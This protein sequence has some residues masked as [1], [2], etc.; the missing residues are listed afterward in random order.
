MRLTKFLKRNTIYNLILIV[1]ISIIT[2]FLFSDV[3]L[4]L[5]SKV[6]MQH[7]G[8]SSKNYYSFINHVKNDTSF[9]NSQNYNYPFGENI[10]FSDST[11]LFST[12]VK[13][14]NSI[15][16]LDLY[17]IGVFNLLLI[18]SILF[19]AWIIYKLALE[20]KIRPLF[21]ILLAIGAVLLTPQYLRIQGHY[22][23]FYSFPIPLIWLLTL[24][25]LHTFK[26]KYAIL[27]AISIWLIYYLHPYLG[28]IANGFSGIAILV[29]FIFKFKLFKKHYI[30]LI[31]QAVLPILLFFILSKIMDNHTDRPWFSWG[32]LS[33]Q[34]EFKSIFLS[35]YSFLSLNDIFDIKNASNSIEGYLYLGWF[36]IIGLIALIIINI[37]KAFKQGWKTLFNN[38][39]N[40]AFLISV[41][42]LLFFSLGLPG[43]NFKYLLFKI[44][45]LSQFRA[46][47]RFSFP[48]FYFVLLIVT[49]G[50]DQ[51][52]KESVNY[53]KFKLGFVYSL[54][55][56]LV[57]EGYYI[58]NQFTKSVD[59][60]FISK[61]LDQEVL[62]T[63]YQSIIPLPIAFYGE[64]VT[65]KS[66]PRVIEEA[67]RLSYIY[68][69][70]IMGSL[71]S[72][73]SLTEINTILSNLHKYENRT[74]PLFN[75]KD[76]LLILKKG[77][78]LNEDEEYLLSKA[79]LLKEGNELLYYKISY[80]NF[81]S[82]DSQRI[83]GFIN[84]NKNFI[85]SIYPISDVG[86]DYIYYLNFDDK[87]SPIHFM[88]T[89][90]F[91]EKCYKDQSIFTL[92]SKGFTNNAY[93][94]SYWIYREQADQ[95]FSALLVSRYNNKKKKGN[96]Q[97]INSPNATYIEDNWYL[98]ERQINIVSDSDIIYE[99][100]YH[101]NNYNTDSTDFIIDNFLLRPKGVNTYVYDKDKERLLINNKPY[102]LSDISKY[103]S[104][105][106]KN[107]EH[108]E[109]VSKD[110]DNNRK[111]KDGI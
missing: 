67:L 12:I 42:L 82:R 61:E 83:N 16:P 84:S 59:N 57:I 36:S 53:K 38:P 54:L 99:F 58:A 8:D 104:I 19:S 93:I 108:Y 106:A 45:I 23:L 68:N 17:L 33:Y 60:F 5:N 77:I 9:L 79:S 7:A 25:Y 21:S 64:I 3:I 43:L 11:P 105:F 26:I 100:L 73:T 32:A 34:Q 4:N 14:L 18:L 92:N 96:W 91:S 98:I 40:F 90:S 2:L 89:G 109:K 20:Y 80:S 81:I 47:A 46:L 65:K 66:H 88:G 51:W 49:L 76:F 75:K 52:I 6:L 13:I 39:I 71:T 110:I 94:L 111:W 107:T 101:K 50:L 63:D 102:S 31:I 97:F 74:N 24:K 55:F 29:Y 10:V 1:S 70:P 15:F 62:I 48:V 35:K 85:N 41:I 72:R 103:N 22:S 69:L 27:N 78:N 37:R 86:N 95:L 28:I 44:P 87:P 30:H 56:L